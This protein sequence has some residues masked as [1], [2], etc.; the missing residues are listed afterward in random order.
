MAQEKA[1]HSIVGGR[2]EER[3]PIQ[4]ERHRLLLT[5]RMLGNNTM[6]VRRRGACEVSRATTVEGVEASQSERG[7]GRIL[8]ARDCHWRT[9]RRQF[10]LTEL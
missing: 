1:E 3:P 5:Q 8:A 7:G 2:T 9:V 4:S 6:E 10:P